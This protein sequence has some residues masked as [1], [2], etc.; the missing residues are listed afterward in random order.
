MQL[1]QRIKK[2]ERQTG[3]NDKFCSCPNVFYFSLDRL[4]ERL[5]ITKHC[6]H[7]GK[8]VEPVNWAEAARQ[9]ETEIEAESRD[10]SDW[11]NYTDEE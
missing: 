4:N 5:V 2:L 6:V 1:K 7:C 8:K 11:K 10:K 9:A 3:A